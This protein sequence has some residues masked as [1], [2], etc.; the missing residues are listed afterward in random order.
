MRHFIEEI[1]DFPK[2]GDTFLLVMCLII[3]GFGLVC[4]ASATTAD[5]ILIFFF[6]P[7]T[8]YLQCECF[9]GIPCEVFPQ[10]AAAF[11]QS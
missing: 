10:D 2:K 1:K 6:L 8:V 5:R 3:S 4:I 7:M 11:H 9:V